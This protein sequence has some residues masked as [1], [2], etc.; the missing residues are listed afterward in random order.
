MRWFA[1]SDVRDIERSYNKYD[2]S[3]GSTACGARY[4]SELRLPCNGVYPYCIRG[5]QDE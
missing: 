1:R 4:S 3:D 2:E 5:R